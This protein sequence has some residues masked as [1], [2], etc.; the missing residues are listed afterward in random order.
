MLKDMTGEF[1]HIDFGH[2][3]GHGKS[4]LGFKRDREPFILS[5][6]MQYFM[7]YF[8][9]IKIEQDPDKTIEGDELAKTQT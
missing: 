6:E 9:E 5:K 2:F 8:G 3:L 1:F 7:K 4:K